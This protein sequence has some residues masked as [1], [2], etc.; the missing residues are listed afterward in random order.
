[1]I[2]ANGNQVTNSFFEDGLVKSSTERTSTSKGAQLVALHKLD[3][4]AD[5]DRSV[6]VSR[7]DVAG[8]EGYLD[9]TA[10]YGYTPTG[11]LAAVTKTGADAGDSESYVYDAAGNVTEQSMTPAGGAATITKFVYERNRLQSSAVAGSGVWVDAQYDPF[12]RTSTSTLRTSGT[13]VERYAYDGFDRVTKHEKFKPDGSAES[14]TDSVFDPFD[15]TVRQTTKVG[16]QAAKATRFV[17]LG[18]SDQVVSEEQQDAGGVWKVAKSYTY[19]PG[20]ERLSLADTPVDGSAGSTSY[21]STNPHTDT[22][23]LTSEATGQTVATY[24]YSAYGTTDEKGTTGVDKVENDPVKDAD[25]VNP[26]RFNGKRF[27]AAAGSYDMGFRDYNPGLNRFT[28]RD[29][30]NGALADMRLGSDPWNTNRYAF[31]GGNPVTGIEL[32][33]HYY[34]DTQGDQ[35]ATGAAAYD[36]QLKEALGPEKYDAYMDSIMSEAP[37]GD[38]T[39]YV[40]G[41]VSRVAET[42]ASSSLLLKA[43][44]G[45]HPY[46]AASDKFNDVVG[47]DT[48]TGSYRRGGGAVDGAMLLATLLTLGATSASSTPLIAERFVQTARATRA[49]NTADRVSSPLWSRTKSKTGPQNALRHFK[50]HGADFPSLNNAA[51]YVADAQQFLRNPGNGVMTTRRTNGDVVRYDPYQNIFG[52]MDSS[53]APK[54]Y[55]KPNPAEHGYATNLDYYL[56]Q[57]W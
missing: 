4:T 43:L 57:Y 27:N 13:L 10:K 35:P 28:T 33:G 11:S 20:G 16:T 21:Y 6:D 49:A 15:R 3:Y 22:E 48:S 52:V 34:L 46:E 38:L 56:G 25:V 36:E 42:A 5:G 44:P 31:A 54:T 29:M 26:Y 8:A 17:Y 1:V 51:E 19:G 45:P 32:D 12:G 55:F 50:D 41:G 47:A 9:Q 30:Y 37:D 18:L 53:G 23:A 39:D 14:V 24:R 2:K 40:A 7:I